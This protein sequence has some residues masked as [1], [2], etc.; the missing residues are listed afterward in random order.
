MALA[1]PRMGAAVFYAGPGVV[2]LGLGERR[3]P[4]RRGRS[5][6][7]SS[8]PDPPASTPSPHA[9]EVCGPDAIRE[10]LEATGADLIGHGI[11]C[12]EDPSLVDELRNRRVPLEVSLTSNLR[13]GAVPS[14]AAHP[15]AE[16]IGAGLVVTLNSDDPAMFGSPLA[17][18]YELA[19][20]Q[21]GL[22]GTDLAPIALA[23]VPRHSPPR[24]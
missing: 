16:L 14:L 9:G 3:R 8:G 18:E 10:C 24:R 11:W 21:F 1:A 20:Q 22:D 2:A 19:C 23:G 6:P 7:C 12:L 17:D 13:T 5:G 15:L 4:A